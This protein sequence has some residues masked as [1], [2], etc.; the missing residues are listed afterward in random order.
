MNQ[1]PLLTYIS[2]FS[3]LL[4]ISVAISKITLLHRAM[5]ILVYY[6]IIALVADIFLIW[7][8][9]GHQLHVGLIHAYYLVEYMFIMSIISIWQ[10]S[11]RMKI[12]FKALMLL[13]ILFWIIAKFTFEPLSGLYSITASASQVLLVLGAGYT[14]FVVIGNRSQPLMNY[15]RFW[16][17]L[18]FVIYYAGTLLIIAL[19]GIL[20]H[21]STGILFLV[22]SMDWSLKI[23]FN[24][25]FAIGFLCP[26]TKT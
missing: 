13:Y 24:I 8:V 26:Q 18:S 3:S 25:L 23:L 1:Y 17:L 19:R 12:F 14:L 21:Y 20:L 15:H 5:K 4:P 11:R 2:I 16:I 22:A 10:E 6:L 9:R 7:F